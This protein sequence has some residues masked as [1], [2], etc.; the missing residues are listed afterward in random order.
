M[1]VAIIC[2]FRTAQR[3]CRLLRG[4]PAESK[5]KDHDLKHRCP[6]DCSSELRVGAEK[7]WPG[8]SGGRAQP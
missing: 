4:V 2:E 7:K 6:L 3:N 1:E 5:C 8:S